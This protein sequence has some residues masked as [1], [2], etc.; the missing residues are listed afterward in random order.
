MNNNIVIG[1]IIAY[2]GILILA[3]I[4]YNQQ[5]QL[6]EIDELLSNYNMLCMAE[7]KEAKIKM[8]CVGSIK[9]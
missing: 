9:P 3:A 2:A 5:Q 7:A 4:D 8:E 6:N 1:F